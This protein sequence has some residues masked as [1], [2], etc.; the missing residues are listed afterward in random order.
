[1]V[2]PISIRIAALTRTGKKIRANLVRLRKAKLTRG[3][4]DLTP[5]ARTPM[6]QELEGVRTQLSRLIIVSGGIAHPDPDLMKLL[7]IARRVVA[8]CDD[9]LSLLL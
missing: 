2:E 9:I 8:D 7:D 3:K 4:L 1:M 5:E 6:V